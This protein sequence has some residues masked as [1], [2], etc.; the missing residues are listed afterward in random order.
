MKMHFSRN[1]SGETLIQLVQDGKEIPFNYITLVKHLIEKAELEETMFAES[2]S[3]EEKASV[4]SM[5]QLL[6]E[7]CKK[8]P[9]TRVE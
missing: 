7:A 5:T 8:R 3:D 9:Q 2:F 1:A 6:I 4:N